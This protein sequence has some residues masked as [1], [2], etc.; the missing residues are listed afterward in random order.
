MYN[1]GLLSAV[2]NGISMGGVYGLIALGLTLIFGIMRIINFAH[3]ALLML[4]MLTSYW[5]W[6]VTGINPYLLIVV[7]GPLMFAVGYFSQRVLIKPVLDAQKDVREPLSVLLL[8]AALAVVIENLALMLFGADYVMAQTSFS[9]ATLVLGAVT[10]SAPRFYALIITLVVA[11]GFYVFLMHSEL[12]RILRATGQD[13]NTASIMGINITKTYAIA[14]GLGTALLSVAG[15][16][17]L[18]FY[19][20]HPTVGQVFM[21]KAFIVVVLGGLGSVPGAL[22]GGIIVGLIE[23]LGAQYMTA[24]LTV[25]LVYATFLAVLFTKPSGLFGSPFEW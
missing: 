9:E 13:R 24:T 4:S 14:F 17:L 15:L 11:A 21:T 23:S 3:G 19:Y 16:T 25:V 18:P 1:V 10:V 12:G 22:L 2:A 7:I 5:V 6:R 20:I 8:T